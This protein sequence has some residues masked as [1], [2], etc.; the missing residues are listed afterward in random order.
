[1]K[2]GL[3]GGQGLLLLPVGGGLFWEKVMD[4]GTLWW[5]TNNMKRYHNSWD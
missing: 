4:P 3:D 5:Y 2:H 1:M